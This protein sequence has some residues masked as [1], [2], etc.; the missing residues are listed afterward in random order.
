MRY[1]P[2]LIDEGQECTPSEFFLDCPIIRLVRLCN[3]LTRDTGRVLK[4][5]NRE[6]VSLTKYDCCSK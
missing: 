3:Y 4:I 1:Q 5:Q 2:C 6:F